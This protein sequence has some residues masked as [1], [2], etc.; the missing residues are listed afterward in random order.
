MAVCLIPC[1]NAD[2]SH[3]FLRAALGKT[4]CVEVLPDEI[5]SVAPNFQGHSMA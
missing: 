4:R 3:S 5:R 2:L 1:L